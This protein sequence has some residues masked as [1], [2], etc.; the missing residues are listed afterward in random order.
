[1]GNNSDEAGY[2]V[3]VVSHI[4]YVPLCCPNCGSLDCDGFECLDEGIDSD[5]DDCP[6]GE[7]CTC[8]YCNCPNS[9]WD[10]G[11]CWDCYSGAHQG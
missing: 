9:T 7:P 11:I 6:A 10:G 2:W 1:M 5:E 3:S 8:P 4:D